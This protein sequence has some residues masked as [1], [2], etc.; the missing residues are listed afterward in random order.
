MTT[1]DRRAL[2]NDLVK[3]FSLEELRTLCFDMGINADSVSSAD[4][5]TLARELIALCERT[6]RCDELQAE[7]AKAR[8]APRKPA[9]PPPAS[10]T[11]RKRGGQPKN[12]N[13]LKHGLYARHFRT[14]E[15][16]ALA[17]STDNGLDDE[18]AM[19]RV[20]HGAAC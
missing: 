17:V 1:S 19:M 20:D 13:A 9:P 4:A 15:L 8:P 6:E 18:I 12:A 7:I 16:A 3:Q 11:P 10:A 14:D 2:R 5:N